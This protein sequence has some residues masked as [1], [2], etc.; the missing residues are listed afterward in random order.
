MKTLI[1]KLKSSL[2][3]GSQQEEL[4]L[5]RREIE[6]RL[7]LRRPKI[8][9]ILIRNFYWLV[10]TTARLSFQV[11]PVLGPFQMKLVSNLRQVSC[12]LTANRR[13]FG[14]NLSRCTS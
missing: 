3:W 1:K 13:T 7:D 12:N 14:S 5:P 4:E 10:I 8:S 2:L 11:L 9:R 6:A